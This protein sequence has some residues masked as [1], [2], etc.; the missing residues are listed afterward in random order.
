MAGKNMIP[1][2]TGG[3]VLPKLIGFAVV[4]AVLLV[5][6]KHPQD[7][8]SWVQSLIDGGESVIDGLAAFLHKLAS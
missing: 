5:V 4:I 1:M 6:V 2:S 7:S 8:A 3:G